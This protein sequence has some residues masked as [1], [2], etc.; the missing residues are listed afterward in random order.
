M[1]PGTLNMITNNEAS[2]EFT[3]PSFFRLMKMTT[4]AKATNNIQAATKKMDAE[5]PRYQMI[6]PCSVAGKNITAT[7][8]TQKTIISHFHIGAIN[9]FLL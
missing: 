4:S 2:M 3:T 6:L 9:R 7:N 1:L 5:S 8:K